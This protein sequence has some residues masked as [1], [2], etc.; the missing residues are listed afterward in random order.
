MKVLRVQQGADREPVVLHDQ[1]TVV[2]GLDPLRRRWLIDALGRLSS[3][4]DVEATGQVEAHGILLPLDRPSLA[5]LDLEELAPA[6]VRAEDLPGHDPRIA[7]AVAARDTALV[8]RR[9]LTDQITAER[10]ALGK[11]LGERTEA[12]EEL[13]ALR[14]GEGAAR[15]ALAAAE[16]TRT[17]LEAELA[18]AEEEATRNREALSESVMARDVAAEARAAA[19]E[20]LERAREHRRTAMAAASAAA[21]ALEQARPTVADDPTDE[22]VRRK[23]ALAEAERRAGEADPDRDSSPAS[24]RLAALERRR[25]ELVRLQESIGDAPANPVATALDRVQGA[26][27]EATPVVAALALAD[28]WR[29]LHQQLGALD[30]GVS[31]E[32]AA[33]EAEVARARQG[34]IEAEVEFNQPV[35]TPEQ[36]AKV[37]AAHAAVLEA[38]DRTEGRF[39]GN[40]VRKKLEEARN[41][42]RRVLERL[43]FATYADY[44]MSSSSRTAGPANRSGVEQARSKLAEAEAAL[45][46]LPGA[47]DR[48]RR[49]TELLQ[50]RDAV[51]PRVA[52]LIG[53][54]PTGPEAEDELR[55][56]REPVTP[57]EAAMADLATELTAAGV[58]VGDPP[59]QRDDLVL[60]ARFY[61]SER[62]DAKVRQDEIAEALTA[63]D[64]AIAG[65]RSARD[66]GEAEAPSIAHLPELAR[67]LDEEPGDHDAAAAATLREARWAEVESSRTAVAETEEAVARHREASESVAHLEAELA[68]CGIEEEQAASAVAA[69]EADVALANGSAFDDAVTAAAE[70]EAALARSTLR[71]DQARAALDEHASG[72]GTAA[73][74]GAA[75]ARLANAERLVTEAAASEQATAAALAEVDAAFAEATA[76]EQAAQAEAEAVDR[77]T[78]VD[79]ID[80]ALMSRLAKVRSVGLAGSIPLVLDDPFAVLDDDELTTI[81]DRVVRLSG[82]VQVVLVSDRE[83]A[84]AWAAQIG[85]ERA[86]VHSG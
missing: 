32:E 19:A 69:A 76:T 44:M 1:V 15:E 25:V 72:S 74:V 10:E 52:A 34:V 77:S 30:T 55:A 68:R 31:D 47:A 70:A 33:A 36:I 40:R 86:L 66:R 73:L 71:V 26:G 3:G 2:R 62:D 48:A 50:R 21:A 12:T 9:E 54:D 8:R 80:W 18:S 16:A 63:L 6:V 64:G 20:R 5:L 37:E 51:A 49:R 83:A 53:H 60:L 82:A 61:L 67:P 7:E 45:A 14:R 11:A 56:L 35:L 57:D 13:D 4:E 78:L 65:A 39:G 23:E 43:G 41:E 85:S 38:Q 46:S 29:D 79:D 42:E 75:E 17:R 58:A 24:R 27:G 84:V 59:H 28:T 81:L 22:L